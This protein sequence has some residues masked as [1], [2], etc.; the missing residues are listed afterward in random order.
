MSR[1]MLRLPDEISRAIQDLSDAE[2]NRL[3]RVAV[4]YARFRSIEPD[5]LLQEAYVRILDG[6][7]NWPVDVDLVKFLT[8]TMRSIANGEL[9]KIKHRPQLIPIANHG[10]DDSGV[11]PTDPALNPEQRIGSAEE[12]AIVKASLLSLFKDDEN[13]QLILEGMMDGMKGEELRELLKLDET[14]YQSKRKLIRRRINR[15]FPG[16][17]TT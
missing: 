7:R 16:G 8:E 10:G 17:W 2:L 13:A 6:R 5:D 11:D 1:T 12:V 15:K 3:H 4:I 9:Q 14:A